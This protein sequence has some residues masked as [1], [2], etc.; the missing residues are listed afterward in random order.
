[1]PPSENGRLAAVV[2]EGDPPRSNVA[3]DM[4]DQD[5]AEWTK[6]VTDIETSDLSQREFAKGGCCRSA[7]CGTGSTGGEGSRDRS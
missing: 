4:A 7:T 2:G 3:D 1:M 6:V 5:E